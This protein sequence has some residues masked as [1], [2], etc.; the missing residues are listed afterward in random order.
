MRIEPGDV[1]A[2]VGR[3]GSNTSGTNRREDWHDPHLHLEYYDVEYR[4]EH[5]GDEGEQNQY[6]RVEG[7]GNTRRLLFPD[8]AE[9]PQ[10][11]LFRFNPFRLQPVN[12]RNP[13]VH[14]EPHP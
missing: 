12:R 8:T 3:S 14:S 1:V 4:Q 9:S 10:D 2:F 5:D 13:F 6:V 7:E 11:P